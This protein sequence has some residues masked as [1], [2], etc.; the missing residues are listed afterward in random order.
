MMNT[1]PITIQVE[2]QVARAYIAADETE[3]RKLDALLSL[4]LSQYIFV[5]QSLEDVMSQMSHKA[6]ERG[7]TPDILA[8]ILQE[9]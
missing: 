6:Q 2:E 3:R 9:A 7:L 5:E 1:I 8:Q 4:Q